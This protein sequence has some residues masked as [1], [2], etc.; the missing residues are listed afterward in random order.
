MRL[1]FSFALLAG[2]FLS[3]PQAISGEPQS[4]F[5]GKTLK[6][7]DGNEKVWRVAE[8]AITGGHFSGN[9]RNE[10]LTFAKLFENFILKLEFK[11]VCKEGDPNAGIQVRSKR[12]DNPPNEM[13]GYQADIGAFK[14]GD[15]LTGSLYDES[16]RKKFLVAS[17]S[18]LLKEIE[19]VGEWNQFEIRC[20]GPRIQLFV[21]GKQTVDYT[22]KE[23]G[24]DRKGQI[25]L[26][27]HGGNKAEA[28]YRKITIQELD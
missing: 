1:H 14:N 24:I 19:K 27:I 22:E 2:F 12:I 23:D 18:K 21:N 25:G 6:G 8:G 28:H 3:L 13:Y 5:D 11:L 16:R 26:Q 10:F 20:Q 4:L 15:S 17:D 9:P 7:W